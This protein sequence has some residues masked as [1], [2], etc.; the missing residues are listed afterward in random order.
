MSRIEQRI[1]NL[2]DALDPVKFIL[3]QIS[4]D[5]NRPILDSFKTLDFM[6]IRIIS[7]NSF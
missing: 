5:R 7:E 6:I 4:I 3:L 2:R 1:R